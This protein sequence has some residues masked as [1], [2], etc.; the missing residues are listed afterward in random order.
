MSDLIRFLMEDC[1]QGDPRV[2]AGCGVAQ[3]KCG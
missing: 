3:V 1:C 2:V